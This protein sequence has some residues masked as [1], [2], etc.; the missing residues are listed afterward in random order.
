MLHDELLVQKGVLID[1]AWASQKLQPQYGELLRGLSSSP[2]WESRV[3]DRWNCSALRF[4][5]VGSTCRNVSWALWL[6]GGCCHQRHRISKLLLWSLQVIPAMGKVSFRVLFLPTEEGSIES[7]LFIN[8]S[9]HGILSY[10]VTTLFLQLEF[11]IY[12]CFK[13]WFSYSLNLETF[14]VHWISDT[15]QVFTV[16]PFYQILPVS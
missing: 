1:E 5:L 2:Q 13:K 11:C 9:S 3:V 15:N 12:L 6:N 16:H 7:S 14:K 4:C 8:T 10:Q